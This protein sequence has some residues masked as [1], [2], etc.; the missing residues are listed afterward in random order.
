MLR[1]FHPL[2]LLGVLA[3]APV[4]RAQNGPVEEGTFVIRIGDAEVGREHFVLQP[5]RRGGLPGSTLR[6]EAAYPAVRP[7]TRITGVVERTPGLVLAAAQFERAGADPLRIAAE[8]A[9][10]RLTVR[11][12]APERESA[13]EFPGGPDLV[14]LDDS[15]FSLWTAV[16]DLAS[17]SGTS[18]RYFKLQGGERGTLHAVRERVEGGGTRILLSG[19]ISGIILLDPDGRLQSLQIPARQLEVLRTTEAQ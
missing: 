12:A 9:R 16:A 3:W 6:A 17:E 8:L 18:L 13:Q 2:I 4:A 11:L 5:G 10:G 15:L 1:S 7:R 14:V 19:G